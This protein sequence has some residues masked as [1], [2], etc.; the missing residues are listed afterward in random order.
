M[1]TSV[2]RAIKLQQVISNRFKALIRF[3]STVDSLVGIILKM[4][5]V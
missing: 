4:P 2:S 1:L 5:L 3:R